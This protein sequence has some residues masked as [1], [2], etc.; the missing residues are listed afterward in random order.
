MI[1]RILIAACTFAGSALA[2]WIAARLRGDSRQSRNWPT[3]S[4]TVVTRGIE[5]MQTEA[6]SFTPTVKYSY[7]VGDRQYVGQQVY[8]TGRVGSLSRPAQRLVDG[9][10]ES[11]PVHYNPRNPGEAFLL[12]NPRRLFWIAAVFG[13]GAFL[14]GLLQVLTLAVG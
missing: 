10:P 14:F 8:R 6:R 4:G 7:T 3:V 2:F 11:I 1:S 12:A 9:L 5:T 13:A